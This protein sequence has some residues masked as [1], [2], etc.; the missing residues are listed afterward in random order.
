LRANGYRMKDMVRYV[1][2]SKVFLEK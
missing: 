2:N 1:V